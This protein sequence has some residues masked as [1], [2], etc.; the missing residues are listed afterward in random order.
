MYILNSNEMNK[1][2]QEA[3]EVSINLY[4]E[5]D[6]YKLPSDDK[7][8]HQALGQCLRSLVELLENESN[9]HTATAA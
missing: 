7:I 6:P 9:R 2:L 8:K 4:N 5:V 1:A 3:V